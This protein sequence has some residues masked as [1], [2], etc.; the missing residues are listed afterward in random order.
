MNPSS[1]DNNNNNRYYALHAI[2][3]RVYAKWP[4]Y[5][6]IYFDLIFMNF[7]RLIRWLYKCTKEKFIENRTRAHIQH[8][9]LMKN[10]GTMRS[11]NMEFPVD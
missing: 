2:C 5:I 7:E 11:G 6:I 10:V 9:R 1:F 3:V 8:T 4:L